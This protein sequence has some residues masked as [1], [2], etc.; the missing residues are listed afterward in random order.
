MTK[1][2]ILRLK[3]KKWYQDNGWKYRNGDVVVENKNNDFKLVK[4]YKNFVL[5]E[6][7]KIGYKECFTKDEV[8]QLEV[9]YEL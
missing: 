6:H 7:K 4:K 5:M 1:E 9:V 3:K 2:E 8:K